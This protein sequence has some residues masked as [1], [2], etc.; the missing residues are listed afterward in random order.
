ML[1]ASIIH[2]MASANNPESLYKI[3]ALIKELVEM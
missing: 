3:A 2:Y 1:F